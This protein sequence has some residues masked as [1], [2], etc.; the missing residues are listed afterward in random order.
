MGLLLGQEE[1]FADEETARRCL[2]QSDWQLEPAMA[3]YMPPVPDSP[4]SGRELASSHFKAAYDKAT[5]PKGAMQLGASVQNLIQ[6]YCTKQGIPYEEDEGERFF[7]ELQEEAMAHGQELAS[8]DQ[9]PVAAQ[10]MWTSALQLR[11]EACS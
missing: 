6:A 11:G 8:A 3:L 7:E 1:R 4:V 5:P 2:A 10:R 9:L